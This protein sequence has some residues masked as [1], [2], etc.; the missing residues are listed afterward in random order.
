MCHLAFADQK[1]LY[2][3]DQKRVALVIGVSDYEHTSALPN[4]INDARDIG[5]A[6]KRL[7]FDVISL[8]NPRAGDFERLE[9]QLFQK[10][11]GADVGVLYYAGHSVQVD[12]ANYLI[13]IDARLNDISSLGLETFELAKFV[14]LMDDLA[15]TKIIIL[16]ACRDNPFVELLQ[17]SAEAQSISRSVGI[18]LGQMGA[19]L[20]GKEL[21]QTEFETYGTVVS[22]AAAP[23]RVAA[24]GEGE[25][26]PFTKAL[27][28]RI[29]EPG[30]EIG[31]MLRG[32][33]ADVIEDTDGDQKPEYL[34]KLTD[35]FYFRV[36]EPSKCD[37]LAVEPYNN[38]SIK[39]VDFDA[40]KSAE[41]IA[42]CK[43]A[44]IKE[45]D[46]PR[47][48]HNLARAYDSNGRYKESIPY[49]KRSADQGYIHAIN[50]LG[51]MYINGQGVKQDFVKGNELLKTARARGHQQSRVNLQGSDF[52]VVMKSAQF[53]QVQRKLKEAGTYA[54]E[55]DGD[56]GAGSKKALAE[57]QL[58]YDL[59]QNGLT[60]ETLDHLGLV[61]IIP[62]FSVN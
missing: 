27:L 35:E 5:A 23:G 4:P 47:L 2:N 22:Y 17:A 36:P 16:D 1:S 8:E 53:K 33:A 43:E 60:L 37:Y 29:E 10:L 62:N 61:E 14:N 11:K 48:L 51:V 25:N 49:Y 59:K 56:F 24:D 13:P 30:M 32:V 28:K 7:G 6:L 50:N 21:T 41:A 15:K 42:A 20:K 34:V 12:G 3:G 45:P 19:I 18:G 58:Q 46:H 39:G 54:S 44:L 26:S 57:Y 52:S 9:Y 38:L 31:R 55:I 40:I